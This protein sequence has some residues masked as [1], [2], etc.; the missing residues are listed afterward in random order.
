LILGS[1][2]F[3][4]FFILSLYMQQILAFSALKSGLGYLAVALT[5]V[6]MAGAAQ[7]LVTKIGVKPIL[8]V[9]MALLT[10][11]LVWFTQVSVAGSYTVDLLPGFFMIGTGLAFSF[12]PVSIAALAGV[13]DREAGLASGLINTSQQIGGA[14]GIAILSTV[15][16]T[17]AETLL[18]EGTPPPVA[19]T[20]GYSWA[21]W[22]GAGMA[23]AGVL[24]TIV[25][26]R[27]ED[28]VTVPGG[29]AEKAV[30]TASA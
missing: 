30:E 16:F 27:R 18:A 13:T 7:A 10:A 8:T 12:V 20:S 9:G 15:A 22:V 4:M 2:T 3:S 28:I 1:I 23:A 14:V 29:A 24:A 21:F 26:I 25:F 11:G 6:F 17:H 19:F 5:A